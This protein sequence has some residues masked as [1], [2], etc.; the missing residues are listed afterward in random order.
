MA[1]IFF[2]II[3]LQ[4][5]LINFTIPLFESIFIVIIFKLVQVWIKRTVVVVAGGREVLFAGRIVVSF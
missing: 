1:S 5:G 4:S 3:L 2:A